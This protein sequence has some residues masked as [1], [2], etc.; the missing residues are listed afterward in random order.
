MINTIVKSAF[1]WYSWVI[2]H[3]GKGL[4]YIFNRM[5]KLKDHK[6]LALANDIL[7]NLATNTEIQELISDDI[8]D[9][10]MKD[11]TNVFVVTNFIGALLSL[12][13]NRKKD[14]IGD[15]GIE[16]IIISS[17]KKIQQ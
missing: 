3:I 15:K 5:G 17:V 12:S 6:L 4:D 9:L 14:C 11:S 8:I 16:F 13:A 10:T 1:Q 7:S 2:E